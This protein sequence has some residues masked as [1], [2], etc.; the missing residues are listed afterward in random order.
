ME[1]APIKQFNTLEELQEHYFEFLRQCFNRSND[2]MEEI[3]DVF[4]QYYESRKWLDAPGAHNVSDL[5]I[6]DNVQNASDLY[7]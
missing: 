7:G 6:D 1:D 5:Y 2:D 4:E 3:V